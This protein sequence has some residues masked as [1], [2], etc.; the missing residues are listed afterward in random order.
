MQDVR[1]MGWQLC[2]ICS[3]PL[4]GFEWLSNARREACSLED[5]VLSRAPNWVERRFMFVSVLVRTSPAFFL[6]V[7][8]DVLAQPAFELFIFL[9]QQLERLTHDV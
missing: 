2:G 1:K 5:A 9:E 6:M 8:A 3:S 7:V 4:M